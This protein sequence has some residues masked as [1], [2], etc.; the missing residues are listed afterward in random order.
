MGDCDAHVD[1]MLNGIAIITLPCVDEGWLVY[2]LRISNM[3]TV[4]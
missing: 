4:M 1:E 3:V 2:C